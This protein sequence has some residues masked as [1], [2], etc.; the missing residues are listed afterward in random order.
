MTIYN[1]KL[2]KRIQHVLERGKSLLLLGARQT[3]KTTLCKSLPAD[4][5]ISLVDTELRKR[6]EKNPELLYQSIDARYQ[7]KGALVQVIVDEI[8]KVPLLMD[9]AQSLIDANK[10]QFVLTGSSARKLKKSDH[11]NLLP[12]RVVS[13]QLDPLMIDEIPADQHNLEEFLLYGTL[14][15]IVATR[16]ALDKTDDLRSYVNTYLEEEIR[17]EAQVRNVAD[18]S[19]F[20]ELASNESGNRLNVNALS[21]DI[22]VSRTT[23][24]DYYQILEDCLVA[25]RVEPLLETTCRRRLSRSNQFIIYDLG[26]RRLSAQQGVQLPTEFMGRLFEQFIGL[27]LMRCARLEVEPCRIY[28]W[29]DL[30]GPEVDWVIKKD[31]AYIPVEVKWTEKPNA[32]DIKHLKLFLQEYDN[33]TKAYVVCRT[34]EPLQLADNIIAIPWQSVGDL[35]D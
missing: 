19:R 32:S 12:G 25:E 30:N 22:G 18:F 4:I 2:S 31:G 7:E 3:G 11:L 20:L 28:F 33:A 13:L 24:N 14:P 17:V 8:Q 29:T 26:I 9:V 27:E 5:S 34:P 1:R 35:L 23:I 15:G 21:Q 6:Y 16:D 10:A